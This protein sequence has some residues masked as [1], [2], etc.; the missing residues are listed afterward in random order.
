[1]I[2]FYVKRKTMA[3]DVNIITMEM[4][5]AINQQVKELNWNV[6]TTFPNARVVIKK[7]KN[8]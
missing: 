7:D 2:Y 5:N 6:S 4:W 1:M 3:F 8:Y